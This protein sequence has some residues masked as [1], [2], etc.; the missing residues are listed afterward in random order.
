M[1]LSTR[2]TRTLAIA[3][4]VGWEG[5]GDSTYLE[6]F[7]GKKGVYTC[8]VAETH[9]R[10]VAQTCVVGCSDLVLFFD[11]TIWPP[12]IFKIYLL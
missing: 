2:Y 3:A 11:F 8:K 5:G 10:H 6:K 9:H 4:G 7:E 1:I 12:F